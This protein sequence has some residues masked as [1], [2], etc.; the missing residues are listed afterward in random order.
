MKIG[1]AELYL[2]GVNPEDFEQVDHEL[3]LF[4]LYG[5]TDGADTV[6][7]EGEA[8]HP[9]RRS[10]RIMRR[11][12]KKQR[13]E[14]RGFR[15]GKASSASEVVLNSRFVMSREVRMPLPD[16][17]KIVLAKDTVTPVD[18]QAILSE[19]RTASVEARLGVFRRVAALRDAESV[20]ALLND[21]RE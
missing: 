3:S 18:A 11:A 14:V 16:K 9:V 4:E 20:D 13:S 19:D 1:K 8:P 7:V 15:A 5:N 12:A 6:Y 17:R 21:T 10:N 2:G